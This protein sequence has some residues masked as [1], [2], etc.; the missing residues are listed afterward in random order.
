M[1][2]KETLDKAY[3]NIPKEVTPAID[4]DWVPTWRGVKYY[5]IKI[6]R[7]FTR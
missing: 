1:K 5:W 7:K 6:V 3:S 2:V 4:L